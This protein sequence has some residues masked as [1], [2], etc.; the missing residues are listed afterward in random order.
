MSRILNRKR[1]QSWIHCR[2]P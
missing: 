2:W 1:H